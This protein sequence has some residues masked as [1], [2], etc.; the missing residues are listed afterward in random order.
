MFFSVPGDIKSSSHDVNEIVLSANAK[1]S[2]S[3]PNMKNEVIPLTIHRH[4]VGSVVLQTQLHLLP[5]T[6]FMNKHDDSSGHT[7]SKRIRTPILTQQN[8]RLQDFHKDREFRNCNDIE[9]SLE[10]L[11]IQ[12]ME[13]ALGP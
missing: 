9:S 10:S 1:K 5:Q 11:C 8:G 13:H 4:S 7:L 12:M 2:S 6:Q 3:Y